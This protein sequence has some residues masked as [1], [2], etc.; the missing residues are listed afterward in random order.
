VRWD[1]ASSAVGLGSN[2]YE[3]DQGYV[4]QVALP[5]VKADDLEMTARANVLTL[6]GKTEVSQPEGARYLVRYWNQ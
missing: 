6:R 3:T 1:G 4:L 5:G 2:L